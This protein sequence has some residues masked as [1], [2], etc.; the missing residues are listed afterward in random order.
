MGLALCIAVTLRAAD[1]P[2]PREILKTV[3]VAQG[4]QDRSVTGQLRTSGRKV[5]FRL[6]MKENTVRWDFQNPPQALLLRLGENSSSLEEITGD[7]KTKISGSRLDDLV[8]DTDISFEDLAMRFLYWENAVIEGEQ[9]ITV[10]KCW[11][12]LVQPPSA[13]ASS[14]SK[15]R[16][17]VAQESGA[18]MKA[19]A[20]G[21]DGK[22][23]RTYRVVSG[24]KTGDGLWMLKQMR[25]ESA[26]AKPGGDRSPTYL[27][28]D[29]VP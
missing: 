16:L 9:M 6:T 20:F 1:R 28:I 11:Q 12:L 7:G 25:I 5:P 24:Q 21:R 14:Y 26:T 4:A 17:W 13:G 10:T 27:E 15:V 3:R 23:A 22:L 8:R 29:K 18:L 19:E 2:D